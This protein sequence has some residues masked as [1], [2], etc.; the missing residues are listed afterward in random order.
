MSTPMTL[1][2]GPT[3]LAAR[4][5][6]KPA[7]LPRSTTVSPGREVGDGLRVAAAEPEVG[8]RGHARQILLRVAE[9][10]AGAGARRHSS[11]AHPGASGLG[12]L[13]VVFANRVL[14]LLCIQVAHSIAS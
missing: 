4:K 10:E 2:V 13:P 6:S 3:R 9:L 14:D 12:N 7:P 8:A 11:R 1:P 5:Q